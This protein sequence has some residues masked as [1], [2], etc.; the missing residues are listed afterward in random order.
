[1]SHSN[2]LR[3]GTLIVKFGGSAITHKQEF[4]TLKAKELMEAAFDIREAHNRGAWSR[5]IL[6]HG[7]GEMVRIRQRLLSF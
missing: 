5:I 7:A 6:V 3:G 1:M 4:E 2:Q